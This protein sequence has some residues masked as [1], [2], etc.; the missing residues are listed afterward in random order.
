MYT[1]HRASNRQ[2]DLH[3]ILDAVVPVAEC[4]LLTIPL[5]VMPLY[6]TQSTTLGIENVLL[7]TC[8]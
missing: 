8:I 3:A 1:P 6:Q 2:Y 5:R 7:P 4:E